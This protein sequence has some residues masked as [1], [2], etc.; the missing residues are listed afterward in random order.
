MTIG[1][2]N[3][4]THFTTHGGR[5]KA[6]AKGIGRFALDKLGERCEMF[7]FFDPTVHEDKMKMMRHLIL[8]LSLDCKL[9]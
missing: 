5:V 6:G 8:W 7:T 1:T 2:D 9:E 3:K 4:S